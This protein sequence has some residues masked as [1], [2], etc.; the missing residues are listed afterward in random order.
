VDCAADDREPEDVR[1][2]DREI[3][4]G[5]AQKTQHARRRDDQHRQRRGDP[6]PRGRVDPRRMRHEQRTEDERAGEAEPDDGPHQARRRIAEKRQEEARQR[7]DPRDQ[8]EIPERP[9]R[10]GVDRRGDDQ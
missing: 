7:D 4:A 2:C 3:V 6:Q 9:P 10:E 8:R 5:R 1:Q